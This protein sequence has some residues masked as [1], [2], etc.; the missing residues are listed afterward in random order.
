[1][2]FFA[3]LVVC[4]EKRFRF[5]T[6]AISL[7]VH[8]F[9]NYTDRSSRSTLTVLSPRHVGTKSYHHL[10]AKRQMLAQSF[11]R[12]SRR[13]KLFLRLLLCGEEGPRDRSPK[14]TRASPARLHDG[15]LEVIHSLCL[16]VPNRRRELLMSFL[17]ASLLSINSLC[18]TRRVKNSNSNLL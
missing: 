18:F 8:S 4:K 16:M 3:K 15:T 7:L 6:Y 13:R 17:V 14:Q 10:Q 12:L 9:R 2:K 1:M 5:V 11:L